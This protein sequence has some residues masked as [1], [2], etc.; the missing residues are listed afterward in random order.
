MIRFHL[1][2]QGLFQPRTDQLIYVED[3]YHDAVNQ[4]LLRDYKSILA[5]MENSV[6][7]V[8]LVFMPQLFKETD[9]RRLLSFS[10]NQEDPKATFASFDYFTSA[11]LTRLLLSKSDFS[12]TLSPGL[13]CFTGEKGAE[14]QYVF[15]YFPFDLSDLSSLKQQCLHFAQTLALAPR[16]KN[17]GSDGLAIYKWMMTEA[18]AY[19]KNVSIYDQLSPL[20]IQETRKNVGEMSFRIL[21][22]AYDNLEI[23]M[24]PL[25]KALY[26]LFLRHPEGIKLRYLAAYQEELT[27][28]YDLILHKFYEYDPVKRL[29]THGNNSIHENLSRIKDAF[30]SLPEN[31]YK[32][33]YIVDSLVES[34]KRMRGEPV[35]ILLDRDWVSLPACVSQERIPLTVVKTPF[36]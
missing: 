20:L 34:D 17:L 36:R 16:K 26:I 11:F 14:G 8:G 6:K 31:E 1:Q 21:L 5:D 12:G 32:Q 18:G 15:A 25:P 2:A 35:G 24:T 19:K 28:I 3:T 33:Q 27:D 29:C 30:A 4:A 13:I 7:W 9:G 10:V 23:K 22:P